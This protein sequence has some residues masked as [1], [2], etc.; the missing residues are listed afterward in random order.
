MVA[1]SLKDSSSRGTG[2][3]RAGTGLEESAMTTK[4][5][6]AAATIFSRVCAPPP[7]LTSQPTGSTWS[8][9]SMARS[10]RS[11]SVKGRTSSP[12]A[13]PSSSVAGEVATHV[14]SSRR[15]P[16]AGTSSATVDPVPRPTHIPFSTSAAA[17]SAAARFSALWSVPV[18]A[19]SRSAARDVLPGQLLVG[20][21]VAR[22][23]EHPLAE[24]VAHHLGRASLDGVRPH[25]QE[26]LVDVGRAHADEVGADH[27]VAGREQHGVVAQEV[28]AQVV[29][30]LVL[31]PVGHLGDR[32]FRAGRARL[33]RLPPAR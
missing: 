16:R 17:V 19:G 8:A 26:H 5:S 32:A 27:G 30:P 31:L 6:A 13:A 29:D 1:R 18:T 25:A 4:R 24:D 10:S 9:P 15:T 22:Q 23:A 11:T 28:H 2:P 20:A 12:T 14:M 21:D 33:A 7:P 3:C